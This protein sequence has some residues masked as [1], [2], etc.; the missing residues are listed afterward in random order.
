[1][2]TPQQS[3][4]HRIPT[5]AEQQRRREKAM[6]STVLP[7]EGDGESV[8]KF[9]RCVIPFTP[10]IFRS[11]YRLT[12]DRHDAED[13]VQEAM[14]RAFIGIGSLREG[15]NENAWLHRILHNTWIDRHRMRQRRP[16]E[17]CVG[18]FTDHMLAS[19]VS[20]ASRGLRSAEIDAL[21]L[22]PDQEVRAALEALPEALRTVVYYADI[23]GIRCKQIADIMHTPLG[24][25]LS[26]LHRGRSRLRTALA[27]HYSLRH[28]ASA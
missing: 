3:K 5:R 16:T 7:A 17:R 12:R 19:G 15:T 26:R 24:T 6:L 14:L 13:L 1:M 21:E 18:M 9:E 22:I 8:A 25:V 2:Q 10:N 20:D 23:A 4:G 11:A 28:A 27:V